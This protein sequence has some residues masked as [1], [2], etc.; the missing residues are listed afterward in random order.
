[1]DSLLRGST[2]R[3]KTAAGRLSLRPGIPEAPALMRWI[4]WGECESVNPA[5]HLT[6]SPERRSS[7]ARMARSSMSYGSALS[8]EALG[9]Q[10]SD[11]VPFF[12]WFY[13]MDC[14]SYMS[15][16]WK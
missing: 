13:F 6:S 7:S 10:P 16:L 1:M 14:V 12:Y 3:Y 9:S 8:L 15:L 11:E 4:E 2:C 5:G